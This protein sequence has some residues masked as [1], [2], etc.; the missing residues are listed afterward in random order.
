[1]I[2]GD[3]QARFVDRI[4]FG[5]Q[6]PGEFN[7]AFFEVIAERKITEH[8]EKCVMPCRVADIVEVVMFAA[9]THAFLRR[10]RARIGSLLDAGEHILELHHTGIGEHQGR[11]IARHERA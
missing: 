8:L 11:I 3:H 2:D 5:D 1:M 4:I 10:G 7:R 9:R 6:I